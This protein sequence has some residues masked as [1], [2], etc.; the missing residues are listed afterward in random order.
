MSDYLI[1]TAVVLL[2][3]SIPAFAP[4]TWSLLVWFQLTHELYAPVL[5]VLGVIAATSGRALLAWYS[6][7]ARKV[8]P[9]RYVANMQTLGEKISKSRR[10]KLGA[11]S[12]F[13][14]SPMSSAQLFVG[15]AFAALELR[16]LL[17]AFAM[18]RSITYSL[19]VGGATLADDTSLGSLI[20]TYVKS[21]LGIALQVFMF[22]L[23]I[24]PGIYNWNNTAK[25]S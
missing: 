6:G 11:F 13:F 19:Y 24:L 7:H 9:K 18:G 3:N 12:L 2:A 17:L 23:V 22:A 14:L 8:L 25:A 1:V 5:V 16:L 21:P 10:G 15:A 4:P 20:T